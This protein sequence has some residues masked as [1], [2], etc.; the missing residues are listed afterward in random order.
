MKSPSLEKFISTRIRIVFIFF[1]LSFFG[2]LTL[3]AETFKV[4]LGSSQFFSKSYHLVQNVPLE[5][6]NSFPGSIYNLRIIN[7][8]SG[9]NLTAISELREKQSFKLEFSTKGVYAI[10]FEIFNVDTGF[11]NKKILIEVED[12]YFF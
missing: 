7:E 9:N 8:V 3:T 2:P 5:F 6:V 11:E 1:L 10:W 12:Q 4:V